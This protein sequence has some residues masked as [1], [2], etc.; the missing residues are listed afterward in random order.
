M[1]VSP[2][3]LENEGVIQSIILIEVLRIRGGKDFV[4]KRKLKIKHH[5]IVYYWQKYHYFAKVIC[6]IFVLTEKV[7]G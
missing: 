4:V 1:I 5:S 3:M 2:F 6:F 7:I